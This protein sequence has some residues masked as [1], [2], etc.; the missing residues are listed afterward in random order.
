[1]YDSVS[2]KVFFTDSSG[3]IDYVSDSGA[4]P[5][6]IYGPI[7]A[8]GN[9]AENPVT[10]DSTDQMVYATFN[11]NGTNAIVVQAPTTLAS[12]ASAPVGV[13]NTTYTGPYGPGFNNAW[14]TGSG[15]PVMYVAGTGSGMLPT[16]YSIGFNAAGVMN[17][18][19]GKTTAALASG[20]ADSSPV[21]EF[22]NA[23]LQKDFLFVGV[24]NNCIATGGGGSAG[25][26]LSMDITNGFPSVGADSTALSAAGGTSGIIFDNDSTDDQASSIYYATKTGVTLVKATQS[27]LN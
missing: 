19:A 6:V 21:T 5:S 22:Y 27:G 14:Y 20:N 12:A 1:V 8:P 13:A 25:C 16:L 11:S 18:S 17:S 10:L 4:A 26:V 7:L 3:R 23:T 24:T 2:N 15:T 9:T